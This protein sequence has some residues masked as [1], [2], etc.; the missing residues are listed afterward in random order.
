MPID[1]ARAACA[2]EAVPSIPRDQNGPVFRQPWEARAFA[3]ALSLNEVGLFTW[4][5]W[6]DMLGQEIKVAQASGDPDTGVTYYRHWLAA[7]E[8]IV[9]AKGVTTADALARYYDAWDR[10]ADRTPHGTPIELAPS[11]FGT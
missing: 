7:L 10:A 9:A 2:T 4:T 1:T 11:D 3:L 8:R 5:E 6:A